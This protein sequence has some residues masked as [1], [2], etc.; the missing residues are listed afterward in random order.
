MKMPVVVV[1]A[2]LAAA[3]VLMTSLLIA[4]SAKDADAIRPGGKIIM[5]P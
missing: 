3:I 1:A 4:G 2:S 5:H